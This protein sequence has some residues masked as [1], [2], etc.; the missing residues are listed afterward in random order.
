MTF[1]SP[2]EVTLSPLLESDLEEVALGNWMSFPT[3]Y[4]TLE[5]PIAPADR[6]RQTVHRLKKL[7]ASDNTFCRKA[8][9]G[10]ADGPLAGIAMWHFG[11][12]VFHLKRRPMDSE[13]LASETDEDREAWS[14]VNEN[15][16][17]LW[18]KWDEIRADIMGEIPHYYLAPL[19]V[20]PEYQQKGVA[21]KLLKE[22]LDKADEEGAAVYLEA[23]RDGQP[24]YARRGF[25]VEGK[26]E[27]YPEMVRWGTSKEK[28][29]EA[30]AKLAAKAAQ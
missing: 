17:P 1:N 2:L 25:T 19:W 30:A 24:V 21:A 3:F 23:S 10:S 8:T 27:A 29:P 5:H 20:K 6:L 9:V 11:N 15:W 16:E 22:V 13:A 4:T 14:G 18:A 7:L 26:S 12:K 28:H